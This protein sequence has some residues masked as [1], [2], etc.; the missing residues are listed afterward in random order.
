M[1]GGPRPG[2]VRVGLI[3][4]THDRL[5]ETLDGIFAG[6]SRIVHAG[7]VTSDAVLLHLEAIAPVTHARGNCDES[8]ALARAPGI[9]RVT[10]GGA[11]FVVC[12]DRREVKGRPK[13]YSGAAVVVT[14]HTHK[15]LVETFDGVV[16]V[17]PGSASYPRSGDRGTVGIATVRED[18]TIGVEIVEL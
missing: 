2:P 8:G 1:T 9:A 13:A 11:V 4:D 14:G 7:D 16:W 17:N 15:P 5:P 3:S 10:E 6:V 18:G 12:H